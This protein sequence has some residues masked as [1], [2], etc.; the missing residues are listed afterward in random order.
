MSKQK[1]K[2]TRWENDVTEMAQSKG[3]TAERTG[4][5]VGYPGDV[6]V[7]IT[8]DTPTSLSDTYGTTSQVRVRIECKRRAR[9]WKDLYDW[10]DKNDTQ[11]MAIRADRK[12]GLAVMPLPYYLDLLREIDSLRRQT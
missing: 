6:E 1:Q 11:A 9:A 7:R 12:P 5:I 8:S 4:R 2:G 10:L 3:L